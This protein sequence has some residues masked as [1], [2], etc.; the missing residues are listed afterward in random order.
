MLHINLICIGKLK[1]NALREL[2][3]EYEKRCSSYFK[4]KVIELEGEK[5]PKNPSL[6]QINK[7]LYSEGKA[8]QSHIRGYCIAMCIEGNMLS[9][10]EHFKAIEEIKINGASEISYIIGGAYGVCDSIKCKSDMCLSMSRMT[11]T[12]QFARIMLLEQIYRISQIEKG[13]QYHK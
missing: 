4:L 7:C 9:S 11:F 6:E 1:E 3:S 5:I 13:T 12:H 10:V 2:Q 8:M